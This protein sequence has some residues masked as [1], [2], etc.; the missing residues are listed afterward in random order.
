MSAT[1]LNQD[2]RPIVR[3]ACQVQP[4]SY[5]K[6]GSKSLAARY[7][8]A[9]PENNFKLDENQEYGEIWMG[10]HP[11]GPSKSAATGVELGTLIQQHPDEFLGS[12]VARKFPNPTN[13]Q[14]QLPFLFKVL[15]FDKALPLQAHPDKKLATQLFRDEEKKQGGEHEKFVDT[16]H[17]PEVAVALSETFE[18][19]VGFR[20]AEEIVQFLRDVPELRE[21]VATDVSSSSDLDR[22]LKETFGK[23]FDADAATV[24]RL[25]KSLVQRVE[26]EDDAALGD[27]GKKEGLA[28]VVKKVLAQ[29]PNPTT[30]DQKSMFAAVFFMNFVVAKR[31][32]GIAVPADCIHAYL[33]GDCIECMATSDNMISCGWQGAMG[34]PDDASLF[35]KMLLHNP[36]PSRHLALPTATVSAPKAQ[37]GTYTTEYGI[38]KFM[39]EF[40]ILRV[41]VPSGAE[42]TL[43]LEGPAI[44]I[45]TRADQGVE[46]SVSADEQRA[47]LKEGEVV[48]VKPG[49]DLRVGGVRG[50]GNVEV[51]AAYC[52]V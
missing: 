32:E 15:S 50:G 25:T 6:K 40:S 31:G 18:A 10:D 38:K 12:K 19:F 23:T 52:E 16:N 35:V 4:Y 49:K 47:T 21:L 42:E 44:Y 37:S 5:G 14:P 30:V 24:E 33:E 29:Y 20:P 41:E 39:Q 26:K 11:N 34:P 27:I 45:V 7:A 13:G 51:F 36:G 8:L 43:R 28:R 22:E 48:F 46:F 1:N 17:K 2:L 3:L 9:T